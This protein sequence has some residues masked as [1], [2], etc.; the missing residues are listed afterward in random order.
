M[1]WNAMQYAGRGINAPDSLDVP[2]R[3]FTQKTATLQRHDFVTKRN[4]FCTKLVIFYL[5]FSNEK[6]VFI[7]KTISTCF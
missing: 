3:M 7:L 5:F 6:G 4:I 1:D 2:L